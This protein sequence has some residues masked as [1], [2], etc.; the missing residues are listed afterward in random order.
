MLRLFVCAG[1]SLAAWWIIAGVLAA[2]A[3]VDGA[4]AAAPAETATRPV[5]SA[6]EEKLAREVAGRGWLIFAGKS[7]RGDFDLW[8][9]RP[10]G[11]DL[12]NLT[13]TPDFSEFNVRFSPDGKRILYRRAP[14]KERIHDRLHGEFGQLITSNSDGTEL[15]VHGKAGEFPW[16]CWNDDCTRISCLYKKEGKI[17]VL[18]FATKKLLRE[19][20]RHGVFQQLYWSPDGK[21]LCGVANVAGADWNIVDIEL[22]SEKVTQVSR[23]LNCTGD[24]FRD[25]T[26]I[27]YSHRQPGLADDW[28]W[29]MIMQST[30]EGKSRTLVYAQR[31]KHVYWSRTSPDDKYALFSVFPA[32]NGID[33]EM[34]IVRLADTPMIVAPGKPYKELNDLYPQASH[35][36]V[37]RLS[38]VPLGFEPDWTAADLSAKEAGK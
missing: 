9:C 5:R 8:L 7:P 12:R 10:D 23:Q 33:G 22:A 1:R 3:L 36:P 6:D 37:L 35:G 17:R 28:G 32:D 14:R 25:S 11:S 24:Y 30:V 34:A 13:N 31:E 18:D 26:R 29:T 20:P 27:I 38:N 21:R 2:C 19:M 16:A 4:P 15:L